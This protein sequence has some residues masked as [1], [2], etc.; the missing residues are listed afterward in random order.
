MGDRS[1]GTLA[2]VTLVRSISI[3]CHPL[4]VLVLLRHGAQNSPEV[5]PRMGLGPRHRV[6]TNMRTVYFCSCGG[7]FK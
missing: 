6:L 3:S 5:R 2:T 1:G 7:K 4:K